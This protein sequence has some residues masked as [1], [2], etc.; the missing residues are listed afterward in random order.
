MH[1]APK[2]GPQRQPARTSG[3][4]V[5][6]R[7]AEA[8]GLARAIRLDVVRAEVARIVRPRP[9]SLLGSGTLEN[10][11][12]LISENQIGLVVV[13]AA[14]SPVQQRNLERRWQAILV[15][16]EAARDVVTQKRRFRAARTRG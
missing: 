6:A 9:S 13:D 15:K 3:R 16:L 8:V 4:S 5:E 7:L 12:A 11:G 10:L 2:S 1:P 14:L